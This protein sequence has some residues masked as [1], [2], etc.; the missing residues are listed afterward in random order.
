ML[1]AGWLRSI[2]T[3]SEIYRKEPLTSETGFS[4]KV[5]FGRDRCYNISVYF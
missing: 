5:V 3:E 2:L 4:D 1:L